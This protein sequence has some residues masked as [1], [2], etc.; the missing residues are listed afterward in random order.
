M[1]KV[2]VFEK[3]VKIVPRLTP[4]E[5]AKSVIAF[6][7]VKGSKISTN[8]EF[9]N[10][11][12]NFEVFVPLTQWIMKS[13]SL[14]PFLIMSE[15]EKIVS[16]IEEVIYSGNIDINLLQDLLSKYYILSDKLNI[17]RMFL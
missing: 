11:S 5:T 17:K 14:R 4:R 10:I 13:D 8:D 2:L 15:I 16:Y 6:R 3:L 9:R 1:F 12:L 7:V